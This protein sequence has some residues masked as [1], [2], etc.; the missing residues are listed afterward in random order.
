MF[1]CILGPSVKKSRACLFS[2]LCVLVFFYNKRSS[3]L[4]CCTWHPPFFADERVSFYA[5]ITNDLF[6]SPVT[7]MTSYQVLRSLIHLTQ[8]YH[9]LTQH[10]TKSCQVIPSL[11]KSYQVLP[12]LTRVS[13]YHSH[14]TLYF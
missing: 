14:L 7:L 12:S 2:S 3:S 11:T 13:S 1:F 8:S 10:V 4:D 5:I 6:L 9:S